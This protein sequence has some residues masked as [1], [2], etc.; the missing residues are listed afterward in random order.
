MIQSLFDLL[1][2]SLIVLM[3]G[4]VVSIGV[5]ATITTPFLA[6]VVLYLGWVVTPLILGLSFL[7]RRPKRFSRYDARMLNAHG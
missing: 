5:M 4:L 2:T 6:P 7:R 3:V 1:R